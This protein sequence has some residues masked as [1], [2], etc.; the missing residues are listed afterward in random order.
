MI[1]SGLDKT[2]PRVSACESG[3]PNATRRKMKIANRM[4]RLHR[5]NHAEFREARYICRIDN[6]RMLDAPA[7]VCNFALRLRHGFERL[8]IFIEHE[9]IRRGHQSRAFR[10]EC[11]FAKPRASIG[12]NS[13]SLIVMNPDVSGLSE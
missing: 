3:Y 7:R 9:S 6:L 2:L 1:D 13:S 12:R 11:P 5:R 4:R 10:P 8:L